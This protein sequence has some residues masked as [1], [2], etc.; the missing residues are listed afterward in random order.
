LIIIYFIGVRG[1]F[2]IVF[3]LFFGYQ[4]FAQTHNTQAQKDSIA[5]LISNV[6]TD[7][8]PESL[9]SIVEQNSAP[10][11][12]V[13]EGKKEPNNDNINYLLDD[14]HKTFVPKDFENTKYDEFEGFN[15]QNINQISKYSIPPLKARALGRTNV[16]VL[17]PFSSPKYTSINNKIVNSLV[18]ALEDFKFDKINLVFIDFA[19]RDTKNAVKEIK[20][21]FVNIVIGPLFEDEIGQLMNEISAQK[22]ENIKVFS[23]SGSQIRRAN[24]INFGYKIEDQ[25]YAVLEYAAKTQKNNIG[26]LLPN[27]T[28]G[29]EFYNFF[30]SLTKATPKFKNVNIARAEFYEKDNFAK[31]LDRIGKVDIIYTV[32]GIEAY[33]QTVE[34]F[35]NKEPSLIFESNFEHYI[36]QKPSLFLQDSNIFFTSLDFAEFMNFKNHYLASFINAKNDKND[37]IPRIS[38]LS[39][40]IMSFCISVVNSKNIPLNQEFIGINGR[41]KIKSEGNVW[42]KYNVYKSSQKEPE[43]V[44][45]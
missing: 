42:R 1:I 21:S 16:A 22:V 32:G 40:D 31:Y 18:L 28:I 29:V 26:L 30:K 35:K 9:E 19:S 45:L 38:A 27:N 44:K 20:N 6:Q 12:P 17:L 37:N 2:F 11:T 3:Y 24:L 39:Y 7:K 41:F 15:L 8:K 23:Y 13:P 36:F 10:S 5:D 33:T 4:T 43:L 14:L 25:A 34:K